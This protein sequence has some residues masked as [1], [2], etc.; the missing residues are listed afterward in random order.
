MAPT[1]RELVESFLGYLWHAIGPTLDPDALL[2]DATRAPARQ[3][4]AL[5]DGM[6]AEVARVVGA[7]RWDA[8]TVEDFFGR[9]V[10]SP[11]RVPFS[12]PA[13]PLAAAAFARR[14]RG[15]GSAAGAP[16]RPPVAGAG[17]ERRRPAA[18]DG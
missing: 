17:A 9:F 2:D 14:L 12:S 6:L 16:A 10:T 4:L 11:R 8:R 3:P 1:H 13:R 7:V 5:P 18:W 15:R